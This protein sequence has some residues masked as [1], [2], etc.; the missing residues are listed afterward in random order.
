MRGSFA[1]VQVLRAFGSV[2]R[3]TAAFIPERAVAE[4]V[5]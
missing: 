5:F 2:L 4:I 1:T 3:A